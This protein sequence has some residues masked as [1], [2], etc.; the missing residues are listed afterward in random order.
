[1][2]IYFVGAG[3]GGV[4][5]LTVKAHGLITR[6]DVIIY[7]ALADSQILDLAPA[8]CLKVD[9]GK[10]GGRV[11]TSQQ[12]INQMLV[13]YGLQY[14]LVIR[15]KSGDPGIFGR[16]HPELEAIA[17]Y[18]ISYELIP[19]ISSVLAAPLW[20]GMSLT[21]K[22]QGR[23]FA[24][25]SG[26]DPD[27]LDWSILASIDTLVILMGARNLPLIIDYLLGCDRSSDSSIIIIKNAGRKDQQIWQGNLSNMMDQVQGISL[28]PCVI[29]ISNIIS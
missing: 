22:H 21:E 6:A 25:V 7:D 5:Y 1:M 24:V 10:R 18:N 13:D 26:H 28:S 9:V 4:D 23:H 16:L 15:L 17:P 29:V 14:S 2:T 27:V 12:K 11:S 19:G 8:H 20:A 3:V